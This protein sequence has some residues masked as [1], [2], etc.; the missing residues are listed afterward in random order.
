MVPPTTVLSPARRHKS[1]DP[2]MNDLRALLLGVWTLERHVS[3]GHVM[4]GTARFEPR[5]DGLLHYSEAGTSQLRGAARPLAFS[6]HYLYE[7]DGATLRVF[8][9]E[10]PPRLF[11]RVVLAQDEAGWSGD[12][13]HLCAPDTYRSRYHFYRAGPLLISHAVTG[14]RKDYVIETRLTRAAAT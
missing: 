4:T 5:T 6:Q 2:N 1:T 3:G 9:A 8:F 12:G 14:P 11:Q 7:I 10:T 13:T